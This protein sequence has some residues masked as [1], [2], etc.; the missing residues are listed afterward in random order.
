MKILYFSIGKYYKENFFIRKNSRFLYSSE[1]EHIYSYSFNLKYQIKD[2]S[3]IDQLFQYVKENLNTSLVELSNKKTFADREARLDK[4][5][6]Y[7]L[8]LS[9]ILANAI[10]CK[11]ADNRLG[12]TKDKDYLVATTFIKNK[13]YLSY[14]SEYRFNYFMPRPF[15]NIVNRLQFDGYISIIG[16]QN[17]IASHIIFNKKFYDTFLPI[18][19]ESIF[20]INNNLEKDLGLIQ[21]KEP[22]P[23]KK[24]TEDDIKNMK[25]PQIDEYRKEYPN[26][27]T[28]EYIEIERD[29][30]TYINFMN[31]EDK[32][33]FDSFHVPYVVGGET[34]FDLEVDDTKEFVTSLSVIFGNDLESEGR[35]YNKFSLLKKELRELAVM[36]KDEQYHRLAEI[37]IRCCQPRIYSYL[38]SEEGSVIP[39]DLYSIEDT[40]R[41]LVKYILMVLP[42]KKE[43]GNTMQELVIGWNCDN[44][45]NKTTNGEILKAITGIRR[46]PILSKLL[47]E[48]HAYSIL[49]NID[50]E[51]NRKVL[52]R[53]SNKGIAAM[54]AHDAWFVLEEHIEEAANIIRNTFHEVLHD[55]GASNIISD[56]DILK[57]KLPNKIVKQQEE[58][59][60]D[61]NKSQIS[62][63][64][65]KPYNKVDGGEFIGTDSHEL[66]DNDSR[67]DD[68]SCAELFELLTRDMVAE[69]IELDYTDER[70]LLQHVRAKVPNSDEDLILDEFW[71]LYKGDAGK[72]YI[73][74]LYTEL[75]NN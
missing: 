8:F 16:G 9:S 21:Y 14:I 74:N 37:D 22:K 7:K 49:Q 64:K 29:M 20:S 6:K 2:P 55:R 12:K 28:S 45:D 33:G 40:D 3:A 62:E 59:K 38:Y 34:E 13:N 48:T 56:G 42:N 70:Q 69:Q 71:N 72:L 44:E 65:L 51:I 24:L 35:I 57:I 27:D 19:D 52:A 26:K 60:M 43:D 61:N 47:D 5:N 54:A 75:T 63:T 1:P 17:K 68:A 67:Y 10:F 41:E 73:Y 25:E 4:I 39:Q 50:G 58:E 66:W 18:W 53:L 15:I 11:V 36:K 32:R 31:N 46:N 23:R 30:Q